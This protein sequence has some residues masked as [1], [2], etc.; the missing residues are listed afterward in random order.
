MY[1]VIY[2]FSALVI[3]VFLPSAALLRS[4][5]VGLLLFLPALEVS[6]RLADALAAKMVDDTISSAPGF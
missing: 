5:G 6:R 2:I 4:A 1:F 3:T